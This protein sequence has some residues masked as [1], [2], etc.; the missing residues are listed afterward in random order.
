MSAGLGPLERADALVVPGVSEKRRGEVG[1]FALED[2]QALVIQ[3]LAT[4]SKFII[5][6][7]T[8]VIDLKHAL[9]E[10]NCDDLNMDIGKNRATYAAGYFPNPLNPSQL[11]SVAIVPQADYD[12]K[13]K[14][15]PAHKL[16]CRTYISFLLRFTT[17]ILALLSSVYVS[18]EMAT[19]ESVKQLP[20][21][22]TQKLP[23]GEPRNPMPAGI[24]KALIDG[25]W[26]HRYGETELY[27]FAPPVSGITQSFKM[28][29]NPILWD[30][31]QGILHPLKPVTGA[32]L[33]RFNFD[34]GFQPAQ[35]PSSL[36][37]QGGVQ[38]AIPGGAPAFP[39]GVPGAPMPSQTFVPGRGPSP[40]GQTQGYGYAPAYGQQ[41]VY[42]QSG[43]YGYGQAQA[44][45]VQHITI[46][47]GGP[48]GGGQGQGGGPGGG[49]QGGGPGGP[50]P[51]TSNAGV[52]TNNS[53]KPFVPRPPLITRTASS[54]NGTSTA[55]VTRNALGNPRRNNSRPLLRI[56]GGPTSLLPQSPPGAANSTKTSSS[57]APSSPTGF[58]SRSMGRASSAFDITGVNG[59]VGGSNLQSGVTAQE[60]LGRRRKTRRARKVRRATRR[61]RKQRG[62]GTVFAF[63]VTIDSYPSRNPTTFLLSVDGSG[64]PRQETWAATTPTPT[65]I[66]DVIQS[67]KYD[68]ATD[69]Q[70]TTTLTMNP[71]RVEDEKTWERLQEIF[72]SITTNKEGPSL[73]AYRA[74][75]LA[76]SKTVEKDSQGAPKNVVTTSICNDN[77]HRSKTIV[78]TPGY[79]T[80]QSLYLDGYEY[81]TALRQQEDYATLPAIL[82]RNKGILEPLYSQQTSTYARPKRADGEMSQMVLQDYA[83]KQV[84]ESGSVHCKP[85]SGDKANVLL[86]AYK[87]LRD[88]YDRHLNYVYWLLSKLVK[89]TLRTP[90][91]EL[92]IQFL[93]FL[94]TNPNKQSAVQMMEYTIRAARKTILS[95][96][97]EVEQIYNAALKALQA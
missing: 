56:T 89:I 93:P 43:P 29:P 83:F 12:A 6:Q 54:G 67:W 60:S 91:N 82:E 1:K 49:G 33:L 4:L 24:K 78:H 14:H 23:P 25:G 9:I 47:G 7:K 73:A 55:P 77:L 41:P 37:T 40:Y 57:N 87:E 22:P 97:L 28:P 17:L 20:V 5:Y 76:T 26:F 16:Q 3:Y 79:A 45:A 35:V 85:V 8:N 27:Y 90:E 31:L 65:P 11:T 32:P 38:S 50:R 52:Q 39:P 15:N 81:G 96:Y 53:T 34:E 48:G 69:T 21:D 94:M 92:K 44:S 75:L 10:K 51:S 70:G 64:W 18:P 74:Y 66:D 63:Q 59:S 95:H 46:G 88:K 2:K 84:L 42:G 86:T 13:Y 62:G 58:G 19:L 68:K 80:V 61:Y 36:P 71:L 30:T 72:N